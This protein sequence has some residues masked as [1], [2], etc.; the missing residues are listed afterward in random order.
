VLKDIADEGKKISTFDLRAAI[1][2]Q[3]GRRYQP[4]L[5][6]R[7]WHGNRGDKHIKLAPLCG[8]SDDRSQELENRRLPFPV[9]AQEILIRFTL[10]TQPTDEQIKQLA[11]EIPLVFKEVGLHLHRARWTSRVFEAA[12][13]VFVDMLNNKRR[14]SQD[15]ARIEASPQDVVDIQLLA[16]RE[17]EAALAKKM[18]EVPRLVPLWFAI[19]F[20]LAIVGV[21]A[22]VS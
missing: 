2:K 9:N 4:L 16:K 17:A 7:V 13:G 12:A 20:V 18:K 22:A 15:N 14:L 3:R 6:R 10:E 5:L 19:G 21:K 1:A 11:K 8:S